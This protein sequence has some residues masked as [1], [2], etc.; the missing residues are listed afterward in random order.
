M[1]NTTKTLSRQALSVVIAMM[2]IST[3]FGPALAAVGVGNPSPVGVASAQ[4]Q[5]TCEIDYGLH[6]FSD[7]IGAVFADNVDYYSCQIDNLV[8][9]LFGDD[10]N[11]V[12]IE[13]LADSNNALIK[14]I[15]ESVKT[16][17]SNDKEAVSP[18]AMSKADGEI[19]R[20]HV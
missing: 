18:T 3:V 16:D 6:R 4:E 8:S 19:G 5:E 9:G 20:A 10:P 17:W 11:S 12:E 1:N 14:D 13:T 2:L 7:P 15:D